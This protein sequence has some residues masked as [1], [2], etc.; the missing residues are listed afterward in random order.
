MVDDARIPPQRA[1]LGSLL[2][3]PG[4]R[5]RLEDAFAGELCSRLPRLVPAAARLRRLGVRTSPATVRAIVAEVHP[6]ASSA[7]V[8]GA[9]EAARAAR[10]VEHRLLAYT[11]GEE[12]PQVVV[13]DALEHLDHLLS[14]LTGWRSAA[15][16]AAV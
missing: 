4:L 2:E 16:A 13:A 7:V 9:H 6:L 5:E 8:V 3:V 12:L 1:A 14:A 11:E 15:G 10:A